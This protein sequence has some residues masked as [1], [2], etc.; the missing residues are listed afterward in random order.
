MRRALVIWFF[1]TLAWCVQSGGVQ[2]G[3]VQSAPQP[4]DRS[5]GF[6]AYRKAND[7]FVARKFPEA[8]SA[9]EQSLKLDERLVPALTLY[10]KIAMAMN[11]FELARDSLERALAVDPKATYAR[12]LYG[13]NFYLVND[14]QHALP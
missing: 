12:F 8:L 2:S 5:P 7:L 13:L 14:L 6:P 10:A 3:S 9:L 11:R 1:A 4:Y